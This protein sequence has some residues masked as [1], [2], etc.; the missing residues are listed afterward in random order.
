MENTVQFWH[1][2][3]LL[4]RSPNHLILPC[5]HVRRNREPDLLGRFQIDDQFEPN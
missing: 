5:Q 4:F 3:L 1:R 2:R